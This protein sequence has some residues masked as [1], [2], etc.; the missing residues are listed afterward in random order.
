MP[1]RTK[2]CIIGNN[3]TYFATANA[4]NSVNPV[5][6]IPRLSL[7]MRHDPKVIPHRVMA[8]CAD[9]IRTEADEQGYFD[10][11]FAVEG[12]DFEI[13]CRLIFSPFRSDLSAVTG[14]VFYSAEAYTYDRDGYEIPNDFTV[15]ELTDYLKD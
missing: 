6:L 7:Q 4:R 2:E 11:Q 15:T 12:V 1:N 8:V 10:G 14:V 13:N 9:H 5:S 3:S